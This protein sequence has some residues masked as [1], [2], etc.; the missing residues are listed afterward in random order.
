M[1]KIC[2][3]ALLMAGLMMAENRI[4]VHGHRGARSVR[5]ENTLAGFE[6]AIAAGADFLE[7][8]LAVTRDNIPVVSHDPI[9]PEA[10]CSGPVGATRVIRHMSVSELKQWDCGSLQAPDFPHQQTAPGERVPT[11]DEVLALA[12]RGDFHFNIETKVPQEEGL[13]PAPE[14]F[15]RLIVEAVRK[16]GL[17]KR[18]MLQSFDFRTLQAAAKIAPEIPRAALYSKDE[19][20]FVAV[21]KEAKASIIAP[22]FKLVTPEKVKRA[23]DAGLTVVP[24]TANDPGTWEQLVAAGVDAIITD[25]PARLIGWLKSKANHQ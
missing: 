23:H 7:L 4:V 20:D 5:P 16:R 9:L 12:G 21:A 2:W 10:L 18:V 17:T 1:R 11:L 3:L 8:D 24:W 14:E 15:V 22:N 13:A 25:D 6:Y 19:R